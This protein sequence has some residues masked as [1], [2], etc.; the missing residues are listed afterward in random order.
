MGLRSDTKLLGKMTPLILLPI[1]MLLAACGGPSAQEAPA[2]ADK[3]HI[4]IFSHSTGWRHK[5]IEPGVVAMTAMLEAE[6]Y[7]VTASEDPEIFS[8]EGLADI[9]ADGGDIGE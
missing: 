9:D 3:P 8:T 6:G 5:S 4:L 1:L 2:A 7:Q